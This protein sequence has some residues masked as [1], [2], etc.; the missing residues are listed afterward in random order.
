MTKETKE[1]VINTDY[2]GFGISNEAL[3]GLIKKNSSAIKIMTMEEYAGK[4]WKEDAKKYPYSYKRKKFK[5]GYLQKNSVTGTLYKDNRVYF[6]KDGYGEAR[7][8]PDLIAVVKKLGKKA[9]GMCADLKIIKIPVD[10]KYTIE[11]YDGIEWIA[12]EHETMPKK[13]TSEFGRGF[14]YN[15]ILFAKHFERAESYLKNYK[16][17]SQKLPKDKNIFTDDYA[18]SL[19]FNGAADHLYELEIPPQFKNK[20]IGKLAKWL[21]DNGIKWRWAENPTQKDFKET[22][23][24]LEELA[25]LID[26]ELGAKTIQADN[27]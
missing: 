16:E 2:G 22:F 7:E 24:K 17:L 19:W 26:R 14:V 8:H 23:E 5:E 25:R 1:I 18:L 11:E 12:E 13:Q 9:N 4:N 20:K 3:L 10:V 27:R 15:L 21:Q 6:L